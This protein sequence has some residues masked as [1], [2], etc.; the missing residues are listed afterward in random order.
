[1]YKHLFGTNVRKSYAYSFVTQYLLNE[2]AKIKAGRKDM[3]M[4]DFYHWY[5]PYF[6]VSDFRL[7]EQCKELVQ[8][9]QYKAQTGNV[10]YPIDFNTVDRVRKYKSSLQLR[11]DMPAFHFIHGRMVSV[12]QAEELAQYGRNHTYN[13]DEIIEAHLFSGDV[14]AF[15]TMYRKFTY[16]EVKVP[17]EVLSQMEQDSPGCFGVGHEPIPGISQWANEGKK[18]PLAWRGMTR[19]SGGLY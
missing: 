18:R 5:S 3:N 8:D 11:K 10:I 4:E 12:W 13:F 16:D 1:M 9:P 17:K 14:V 6:G 7:R 15:E 19:H 2:R